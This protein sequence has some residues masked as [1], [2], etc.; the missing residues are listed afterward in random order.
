MLVVISYDIPDN[1]TRLRVHN[2]LMSWGYAVQKSV[3]EA[4]LSERQTERMKERLA[5]LI[6]P[7]KDS[8]R[9]YRLCH[10]CERQCEYLGLAEPTPDP[11]F[12]IV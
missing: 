4:H 7:E 1:K 2:E 11:D 9:I 12:W 6:E 10:R 3:F 8:I 5:M